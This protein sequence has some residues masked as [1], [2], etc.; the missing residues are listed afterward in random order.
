MKLIGE[1]LGRNQNTLSGRKT[2]RRFLTQL[3]MS[4]IKHDIAVRNSQIKRGE[5][6]RGGHEDI[7][8]CGCGAPGCAIHYKRLS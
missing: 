7:R 4:I 3:D 6:E 8:I 2:G 1:G 5:I